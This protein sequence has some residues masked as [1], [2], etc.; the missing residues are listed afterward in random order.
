[1]NL[2]ELKNASFSD[3]EDKAFQAIQRIFPC[4]TELLDKIPMDKMISYF[5]KDLTPS[6]HPFLIRAAGQSGSGKSSQIVPALEYALKKQRYIRLSVG[7]FAVFHP[8]Y[9]EWLQTN[10]SKMREKTNGFAL[11]ALVLFYRYCILNRISVLLDMTLLEPEIDIYLMMLAKK[12]NYQIQMH[13][14]CVPKKVSNTFIRLRQAQTGRFVDP[15]S[16]NYFFSALGRSLKALTNSHLFKEYDKLILWSHYMSYPIKQ[17]H[18]DNSSVNRLL[19]EYQGKS[20]TVKNPKEL[21]KVKKKWMK[22]FM[23][24]INV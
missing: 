18:L 14:L 24:L 12:M 3:I 4:E 16:G 22:L 21:L 10:P 8:N 23:E 2:N 1:M 7:S 19:N 11:R 9:D 6:E 13:L 5:Q 17:T 15:T 20:F